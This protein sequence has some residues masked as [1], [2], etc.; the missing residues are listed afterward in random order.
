ML[1][2]V[3]AVD[4][5]AMGQVAAQAELAAVVRADLTE[6]M[7]LLELQTLAAVAEAPRKLEAEVTLDYQ[8]L[9]VAQEL[10]LPATQAPHKK[11]MAEQ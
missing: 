10:L 11:L 7:L 4:M 2:A 1:A 5:A 3:A 6:V 9:M 8:A